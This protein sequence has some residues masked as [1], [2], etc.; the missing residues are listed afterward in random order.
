[1]WVQTSASSLRVSIWGGGGVDGARRGVG[2]G[3]RSERYLMPVGASGQRQK[4]AGRARSICIHGPSV[5]RRVA[6]G[7]LLSSRRVLLSPRVVLR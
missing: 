6:A 2:S 4:R 7:P 3:V 5:R 1:M